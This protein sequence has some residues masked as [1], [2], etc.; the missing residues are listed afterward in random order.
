MHRFLLVS[1]ILLAIYDRAAAQGPLELL[2][3][4]GAAAIA[5]RDLSGLV[6]KGDDFLSQTEINVPLRPSRL[7]EE[8]IQFLNLRQGL[9][10][11]GAAAIILMSP[12]D[13]DERIGLRNLD[14]L[15]VPAVPFS[16]PDTMASNFGIAKGKLMPKGV[17]STDRNDFGRFATRNQEHLYLSDSK[18]TLE[19][20]MTSK[21]VADSFSAAQRKQLNESDILL[22][23]GRYLWGTEYAN[24]HSDIAKRIQPGDDPKEKEFAQQLGESLKEVQNA[25]IGIRLEAGID[26]HFVAAVPPDGQAA[27]MFTKLRDKN[28]PSSLRG[29]PEGNVLLA[30]AS[31][32]DATH[33]ALLAKAL[34]NFMLEDLLINQ[35]IVHHMDRLTYLGV[36][37]EVWRRLQG[38]RLAVYQNLDEK[39][40]G[41]F[42]AVAIL[43]TEDAKVFLRDMKI[44]SKM[45]SADSL[46]LARKEVKE[47]IDIERV[48]RDLGSSVYVVRQSANTKLALI[49]EPALPYLHKAIESKDFDLESKR[50]ARELRDR[51]SAVAAQRRKELLSEKN[52]P[53]FI[54][55]T[56][57][58]VSNVEK[59]QG[60]DIDIIRIQI[61]GLEKAATHQYSQLLGPDWD[62]VRL[63]VAGNQVVVLLGSDVAL[64]DAALGN[65]QKGNAGLAGSKRLAAFRER[66]A[67]ERQ[68]EFHVSVEG[69]MRLI[70]PT[71]KLDS[72][73]QMTSMSV[74]LGEHSLQVDARV[75]APEVRA[76]A[77]KAQQ[78]QQ[79]MP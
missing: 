3:Q 4:D 28:K 34:F 2:P 41:L 43:D 48:V 70:T 8:A 11:N 51:I 65:V 19:R 13:K 31:S 25:V 44:L 24:F 75:P 61:A 71:A 67:K 36:F 5:V 64:F 17:V 35:K 77:R 9:N 39:K 7:F 26:L 58:F 23:L 1:T 10:K 38:N 16:D 21:A 12:D 33:Q 59:R 20:L 40:L 50:R 37:H 45:A 6:K 73:A 52:Q 74:A 78:A 46:D 72:P 22:H 32:G 47:E 54:R 60:L 63:A 14:E 76:I 53:L 66:A 62:K 56:L 15:L 27:K 68:F 42:S 57:T 30:Q 69:A 49:G 18:K 55:P 29:L 79:G